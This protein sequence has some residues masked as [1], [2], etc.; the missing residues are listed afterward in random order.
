MRRQR[1]ITSVQ[2]AI[3]VLD[4]RPERHGEGLPGAGA[5]VD[6]VELTDGQLE[7]HRGR[8]GH[9]RR[10][11]RHQRGRRHRRAGQDRPRSHVRRSLA[12]ISTIE[13]RTT[14]P[15]ANATCV[16]A[17]DPVAG[18][19][20]PPG[21]V[22]GQDTAAADVSGA[23]PAGSPSVVVVVSSTRP[24]LVVVVVVGGC[25]VVVVVVGRGRRRGRRGRAGRRR[26]GRRSRSSVGW[27]GRR[28]AGGRHARCGGGRRG[29]GLA[30]LEPDTVDG[31]RVGIGVDPDR[32]PVRRPGRR[33]VDHRHLG[34]DQA[35]AGSI[36]GSGPP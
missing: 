18:N 36:V 20:A 27:V 22:S 23:N 8:C 19:V 14:R 16:G 10:P 30:D 33:L 34:V 24:G 17:P 6:P 15:R 25:V 7:R 13:P 21:G 35:L 2:H 1:V 31:Q 32:F 28:R 3:A 26:R 9:R 4:L 29:G 5:R 11:G 12:V